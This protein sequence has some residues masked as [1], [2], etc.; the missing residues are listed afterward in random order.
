[1]LVSQAPHAIEAIGEAAIVAID[2][3]KEPES[4]TREQIRRHTAAPPESSKSDD[5]LPES[6]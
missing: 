3:R 5:T 6:K 1:L 2:R 4:I